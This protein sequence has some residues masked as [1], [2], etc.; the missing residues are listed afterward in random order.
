MKKN[1]LILLA[2]TA[3]CVIFLII[4][5]QDSKPTS[6]QTPPPTCV[7]LGTIAGLVVGGGR[8]TQN[9]HFQISCSAPWGVATCPT[10]QSPLFCPLSTDKRI[11]GQST[12]PDQNP[13]TSP[14]TWYQCINH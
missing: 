10:P 14:A 5:Y 8:E 7:S 12:D 13:N 3:L 1:N 11:T 4:L 2:G 6:A 9:I